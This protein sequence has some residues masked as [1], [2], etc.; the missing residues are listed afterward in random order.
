MYF[1]QHKQYESAGFGMEVAKWSTLSLIA[2]HHMLYSYLLHE[3]LLVLVTCW[4]ETL[5]N[6]ENSIRCNYFHRPL[7]SQLIVNIGDTFPCH[8]YARLAPVLKTS[9]HQCVMTYTCS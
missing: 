8:I 7:R 9:F 2:H 3:K 6:V 5:R 4:R 1:R